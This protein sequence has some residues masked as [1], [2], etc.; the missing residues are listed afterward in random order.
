MAYL[1]D[2]EDNVP[3][4][5]ELLPADK[6]CHQRCRYSRQCWELYQCKGENR[7]DFP[8][9]CALFYKL[10]DLAM[11]ARDL[12][13]QY[14]LARGEDDD[15]LPFDDEDYDGPEMEAIDDP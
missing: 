1:Y 6:N 12:A 8:D 5:E 9:E 7:R 13:E 2:D 10:D 15:G 14:R 3:M 11:E 4:C